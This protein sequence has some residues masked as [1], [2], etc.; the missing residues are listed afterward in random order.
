MY[1]Y[2]NELF[3][4]LPERIRLSDGYTRTSLD[5]LSE[6]ELNNLA[7]YIC[8]VTKPILGIGQYYA[9]SPTISQNGNRITV[10]YSVLDRPIEE[11]RKNKLEDL[12]S[13]RFTKETAGI[14]LNGSIIA[15][16]LVSQAK[17]NGAW[18]GSQVNPNILINW[19]SKNGW[20]KINAQEITAIAMSVFNYV[21]ACYTNEEVHSLAIAALTTNADIEAY[22][23]TTG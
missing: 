7:I 13:Y 3:E 16:D 2:N 22:D 8:D 20:V 14:N 9:S 6:E 11:F 19:K 23:F 17:I 10:V 12:A 21:Q 1:F 15:T 5:N 18:S 4:T